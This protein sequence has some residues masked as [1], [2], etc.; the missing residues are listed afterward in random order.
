MNYLFKNFL[1]IL[2]LSLACFFVGEAG[3]VDCKKHSIYCHIK[4]VKPKMNNKKAMDLSNHIYR[5]SRK[6]DVNE[7]ILT[8]IFAQESGYDISAMNCKTGLEREA[9]SKGEMK[10]VEVCFDF[11]IGQINWKNIKNRKLNIVKI[12]NNYEYSIDIAGKILYEFKIKF[13]KWDES[14]WTRYNARNIIKRKLYK[15]LVERY[16]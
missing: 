2:F 10:E 5:T 14:Y 4:K 12:L 13:K 15:K 8:A 3:A 6:Y 1:L 11:G 7:R 9:L 16:L